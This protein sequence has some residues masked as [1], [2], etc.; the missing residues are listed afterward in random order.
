[1]LAVWLGLW[2]SLLLIPHIKAIFVCWK[3]LIWPCQVMLRLLLALPPQIWSKKNSNITVISLILTNNINGFY[4]IWA[5]FFKD[6]SLLLSLR[7]AHCNRKETSCH[8]H[9]VLSPAFIFGKE[10]SRLRFSTV[11]SHIHSSYFQP[12]LKSRIAENTRQHLN[13]F[14]FVFFKLASNWLWHN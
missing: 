6:S 12:S 4:Y 2:S 7:V 14:F 11:W 9:V 5:I 10:V 3:G 13:L 8:V 1:M